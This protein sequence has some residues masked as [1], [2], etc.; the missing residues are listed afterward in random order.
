MSTGTDLYSTSLVHTKER[1]VTPWAIN[2]FWTVLCFQSAQHFPAVSY[3]L[4]RPPE[5]LSPETNGDLPGAVKIL[6]EPPPPCADQ[7]SSY[8]KCSYKEKAELLADPC[9]VPHDD[10]AF[11]VG[12]V[13]LLHGHPFSW[14]HFPAITT[15][16]ESYRVPW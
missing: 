13:E 1:S 12:S 6:V 7:S 8:K 2:T 3:T 5:S 11:V 9:W 10:G 16:Q 14:L 4:D 15:F